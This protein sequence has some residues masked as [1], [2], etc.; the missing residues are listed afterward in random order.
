[1]KKSFGILIVLLSLLIVI[2]CGESEDV[3]ESDGAEEDRAISD[4]PDRI[5]LQSGPTGGGWYSSASKIGEIL[6]REVDGLNVTVTEGS[7]EG[8]IRDVSDG[9]AELGYTYSDTLY[10]AVHGEGTFEDE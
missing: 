10:T 8:N 9:T 2:G 1:M 3:S 5:I 6:M 4:M 7:A